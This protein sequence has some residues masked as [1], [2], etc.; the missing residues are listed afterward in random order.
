[1]ASDWPLLGTGR[2][3]EETILNGVERAAIKLRQS[4]RDLLEERLRRRASALILI[5]IE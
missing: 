1:M 4:A 3:L 5:S 2:S